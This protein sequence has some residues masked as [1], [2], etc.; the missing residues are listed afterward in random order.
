M[1]LEW[2]TGCQ[3]EEGA[4]SDDQAKEQGACQP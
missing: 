3:A 4:A 2:Q 1:F